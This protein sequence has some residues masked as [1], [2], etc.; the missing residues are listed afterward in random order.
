MFWDICTSIARLTKHLKLVPD[1]FSKSV[2]FVPSRGDASKCK[3]SF[4]LKGRIEKI[5]R[6]FPA[7]DLK[8][9][10]THDPATHGAATHDP[11]FLF[12]ELQHMTSTLQIVFLASPRLGTKGT[13]LRDG[14]KG[15]IY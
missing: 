15:R 6:R 10:A 13:D 8:R 2:P 11:S 4:Q 5:F 9:A 3:R 12:T 7:D 1:I 14:F